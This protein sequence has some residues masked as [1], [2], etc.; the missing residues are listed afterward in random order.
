MEANKTKLIEKM[1]DK[2]NYCLEKDDCKDLADGISNIVNESNDFSA[3]LQ[4]WLNGKKVFTDVII[5]DFSLIKLA[6][7]LDSNNPNIPVAILI[8]W[9]ES[10]DN[11]V[12]HG[13]V[14][15]AN[16]ICVANPRIILGTQCK[17]TAFSD[18]K[19]YFVL[20]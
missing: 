6:S 20:R 18:G 15:V 3:P 19:W 16:Y 8:L 7:G 5:N 11:T 9:L 13:L 2:F 10:Q 1:Y 14:A 17:Y 4:E 12:Y